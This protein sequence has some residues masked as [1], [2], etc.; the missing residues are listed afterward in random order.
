METVGIVQLYC[1]SQW[2]WKANVPV[3]REL[4]AFESGMRTLSW[5]RLYNTSQLWPTY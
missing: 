2:D 4:C 3:A 1:L 5:L